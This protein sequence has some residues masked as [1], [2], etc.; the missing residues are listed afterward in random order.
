[1]CSLK[2]GQ[3]RYLPMFTKMNIMWTFL[4]HKLKK[5]HNRYSI[6]ALVC[7]NIKIRKPIENLTENNESS[8]NMIKIIEP[9]Y[10]FLANHSVSSFQTGTAHEIHSLDERQQK[11]K[12]FPYCSRVIWV[13]NIDVYRNC[14]ILHYKIPVMCAKPKLY[15]YTQP[16]FSEPTRTYVDQ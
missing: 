1:M 4:C 14:P 2:V 8:K 10:R 15:T 16:I 11:F 12:Q 9:I 6:T 7:S 13:L 5:V 3:V